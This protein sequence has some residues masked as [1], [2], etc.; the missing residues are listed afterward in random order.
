MLEKD[1][2]ASS[3]RSVSPGAI[4][5]STWRACSLA[6]VALR[7]GHKKKDKEVRQLSLPAAQISDL[8]GQ[9]HALSATQ[10]SSTDGSNPT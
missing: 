2:A 5:G 3:C 7:A 8:L 1:T 4:L 6:L 9:Q 10:R